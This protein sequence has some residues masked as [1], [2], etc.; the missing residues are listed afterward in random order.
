[1]KVITAYQ[2]NDGKVFE[3][4]NEAVEHEAKWIYEKR[5]DEFVASAHFP[6]DSQKYR[7]SGKTI[8]MAWEAHKLGE[9]VESWV[10]TSWLMVNG[11]NQ[12]EG[13]NDEHT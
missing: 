11:T 3:D 5:I 13:T 4:Q 12:E 2:T 8:I 7:V 6:Y 9:R 10:E 1:M